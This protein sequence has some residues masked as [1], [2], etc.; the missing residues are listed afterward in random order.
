M[1]GTDSKKQVHEDR[2][3]FGLID[4]IR[5]LGGLLLLNAFFSWWFTSSSLWGYEGKWSNLTYINFQLSPF[6][7]YVNLTLDELAIYD[8]T[9]PNVPIYVA[10]NGSVFDVS[11]SPKIYGPKGTYHKLSGKDSARVFVTGCFQKDDEFTYDLRGLDETEIENDIS[12]WKHFFE[13][14]DKYWYVGTVQ[15]EPL[16]GEPP[17]PCEHVK[18]PGYHNR[19]NNHKHKHT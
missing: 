12:Q 10:V 13:D 17:E 8:G 5:V 7:Q 14:S 1:A 16:T 6:S 15:H 2:A 9:N 11:S 4:I 3:S 18:F 19:G